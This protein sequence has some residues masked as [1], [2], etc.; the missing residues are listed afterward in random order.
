MKWLVFKC[1][2]R[3]HCMHTKYDQAY[4]M[5]QS[6]NVI[7]FKYNW[8][9]CL[10]FGQKSIRKDKVLYPCLIN[11]F[12]ILLSLALVYKYPFLRIFFIADCR[13]HFLV[14]IIWPN[15][16]SFSLLLETRESWCKA[17]MSPEKTALNYFL[18]TYSLEFH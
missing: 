4:R 3:I 8:N 12:T 15:R 6:V 17:S 13:N 7:I 10:W 14:V 16:N 9:E 11:V 2:K 1:Y 18:P 5:C